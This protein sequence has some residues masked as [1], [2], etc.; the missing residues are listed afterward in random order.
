M[1]P[2][3]HPYTVLFIRELNQSGLDGLLNRKIQIRP[4]AI[5]PQNRFDFQSS[6]EPAALDKPDETAE[7]D[8]V[9]FQF[10]GA[11]TINKW[12]T[13]LHPKIFLAGFLNKKQRNEDP[14]RLYK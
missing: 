5:Y 4:Q 2:L 3:Y 1:Y 7:K 6:Y 13:F 8:I 11:Y 10:G 9:D 12:E 14:N